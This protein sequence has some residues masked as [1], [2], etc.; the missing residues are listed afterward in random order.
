MTPDLLFAWTLN[1]TARRCL[2]LGTTHQTGVVYKVTDYHS[3]DHD[4]Q[5]R[6]DDLDIAI[7]WPIT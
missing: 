3:P 4:R 6:Y 7:D 2:V 5:I 1:G